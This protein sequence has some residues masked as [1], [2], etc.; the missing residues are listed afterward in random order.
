MT[1]IILAS[2]SPFR[3][4]LMKNAGLTFA[5]EQAQ[6]DERA[7][8]TALQKTGTSPEDLA[9]ILSEAKA[10][11]VSERNIDALVIGSDQTLSLGDDVL[12]KASTMDDAQRRLLQLSGRTHQLNSGA[13]LARNGETLWRHVSVARLTMR[14]LTPAFIGRHLAQAGAKVLGSV[15]CYQLEGEGLQLF[16]TIEGDYFTIVGLPMLPLLKQLRA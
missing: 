2:K 16:E 8:E 9:L 15:G 4:I 7:I 10:L 5:Q 6:I 14:D 3:A 12:H 1:R 11:D 13:V